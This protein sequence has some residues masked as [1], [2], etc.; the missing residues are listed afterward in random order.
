MKHVILF[1]TATAFLFPDLAAGQGSLEKLDLFQAGMDGYALY[2][3][4]GI[5]VTSRG[6]VLAWCEARRTGKSDWDTIDILL[7]RSTDG[8]RTWSE[9]RKIADVPGPKTKNPVALA[10]KLASPD[11]VTYN[12]PVMI[13]DRD[14]AVHFLFCLEYA[15]C[16]YL[17]SNDDG[18][19]WT[20]P[21]EIT[22]TFEAFRPE[23]DWKVLAAGPGHG[24]QLKSGRLVVPVWLST[25]TGGHAHRPSV[26]SVIYS[27]NGGHTWRPG[28]V[29]VPNTD[30]WVNPSE[31]V[32]AELSDG[33][34]MLNVRS[35]SKVHRRLIVIS[36]DGATGWSTPR[37]DEA[38]LEPICMA[39][40]IRGPL[41]P[42]ARKSCLLFA[43]PDNLD[44]ADGNAKEGGSRDRRNLTIRLSND[45]GQSW[46]IRRTLEP[47]YSAYSDLAVLP[48]GAILCL[49]ERGRETDGQKKPTSYAYLTLARF[50]LPWLTGGRLP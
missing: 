16:F 17:H 7:R 18:L 6:V 41:A 26:A 33:R 42:N 8:G 12:N 13:A 25:G 10:Q 3:I 5:V 34:V 38:L 27:D 20:E 15:R 4:P 30:D 14:G 50:D 49:Y 37:F 44:R 47:G 29:A 46:P 2:R 43:N 28:E 9:P 36:L 45:D 21:V 39:S 48:D 40:L 24:I 19:T 22:G 35:E 31:T 23:Y 11:D 1:L 32:A